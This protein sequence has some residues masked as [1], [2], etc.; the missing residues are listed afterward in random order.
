M[1]HEVKAGKPKDKKNHGFLIAVL[2]AVV[3]SFAAIVGIGKL[4]DRE[5]ERMEEEKK[6]KK[7][8]DLTVKSM[9]GKVTLSFSQ[10]VYEGDAMKK[11]ELIEGYQYK[12]ASCDSAEAF[13]KNVI[14]AS[15]CFYGVF[16]R[17]GVFVPAAEITAAATGG[18]LFFKDNH[19]FQMS[20]GDTSKVNYEKYFVELGELC[21]KVTLPDGLYAYLTF[22]IDG[23]RS[24]NRELAVGETAS[25]SYDAM[26][27]P[28]R[29][30]TM[31]QFY[32]GMDEA[33]CFIDEEGETI[34]VKLFVAGDRTTDQVA[35]IVSYQTYVEISFCTVAEIQ[36]KFENAFAGTD[37]P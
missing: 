14:A 12:N 7:I 33:H 20:F 9:D 32:G 30:Q 24:R 11:G 2:I 31:V 8:E 18:G 28:N 1:D 19:C 35:K 21:L 16:Q 22:P 5:N 3:V 29:F 37:T 13:Y 26:V 4:V 15:P 27:G 34:Y 10:C 36:A 6:N 23:Y 25:I 17:E